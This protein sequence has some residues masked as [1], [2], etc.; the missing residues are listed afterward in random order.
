MWECCVAR[1]PRSRFCIQRSRHASWKFLWQEPSRPVTGDEIRRWN[2]QIQCETFKI[3]RYFYDSTSRKFSSGL[4]VRL[5]TRLIVSPIL[6][7]E[8]KLP[9]W[10]DGKM[11]PGFRVSVGM[12][13][14]GLNCYMS[15][16]PFNF[17]S[18]KLNCWT[19]RHFLF[20]PKGPN[21]TTSLMVA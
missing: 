15:S 2:F 9:I 16:Q 17:F 20:S 1:L 4:I 14:K 12:I 21:P 11:Y 13:W 6:V 7:P 5:H 18:F 19:R 3:F 10:T 8:L